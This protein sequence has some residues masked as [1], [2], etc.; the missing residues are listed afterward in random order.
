[1]HSQLH[2]QV[3]FFFNECEPVELVLFL[4]FYGLS[5]NHLD[6]N[7]VAATSMSPAV[8]FIYNSAAEKLFYGE[9]WKMPKGASSVPFALR[10]DGGVAL[11]LS[12]GTS[13]MS[14]RAL[15]L[16]RGTLRQTRGA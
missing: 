3:L 9:E 4:F 2:V 1:M 13:V 12:T 14:R 15:L 6:S 11:E 5:S 16:I 10:G 8:P 7:T